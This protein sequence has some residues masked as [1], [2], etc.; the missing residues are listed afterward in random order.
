MQYY[1]SD[2]GANQYG[3]VALD[4]LREARITP[5]TLV[6]RDGLPSW[7]PAETVPELKELF[8]PPVVQG[9]VEEPQQPTAGDLVPAYATPAGG[10]QEQQYVG[11]QHAP[12]IQPTNG[13]AVASMIL[14]IV[15]IVGG[16]LVIPSVLAIIFGHMARGQIRRGQGSGD[17]MA[18]A[19]LIMGYLWTALT[20][21]VI[22]L[23]V[24]FF[25]VLIGAA[26]ASSSS[27]PRPF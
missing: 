6:W 12:Q 18:L 10:Q 17:G 27:S 3:P 8:A 7:V 24:L 23:Y 22:L 26:A 21:A 25:V 5:A 11:Y 19:G 14:G 13:M 1:Y 9:V 20:V 4:Q 2:N 15:G 16:C